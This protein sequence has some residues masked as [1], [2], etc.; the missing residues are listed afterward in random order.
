[1]FFVVYS[2]MQLTFLLRITRFKTSLS[3]FI[4]QLI[5]HFFFLKQVPSQH[6]DQNIM[7]H[8]WVRDAIHDINRYV[9]VNE[10][11]LR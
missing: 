9:S 8:N 1:M 7:T 5:F 2:L 10:S 6:S 11:I 3:R 4:V